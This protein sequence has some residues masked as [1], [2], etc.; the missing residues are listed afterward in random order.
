MTEQIERELAELFR[1]RAERLDVLPPQSPAQVRRGRL[2][3]GLALASVLAVLAGT[4]LAGSRL[5][6]GSPSGAPLTAA[7][8]GQRALADLAKALRKTLAG[9]MVATTTTVEVPSNR[10]VD[11]PDLG[12]SAAMGP[13]ESETTTYDGRHGVAI[14]TRPDGRVDTVFV[15]DVLYVGKDPQND[16]FLPVGVDWISYTRR[17]NESS[18]DWKRRAIRGAIPGLLELYTEPPTSVDE[19]AGRIRLA[20]PD[21][22]GMRSVTV[23]Q[24]DRS[25]VIRTVT[26]RW[27]M[28][29][30][31]AVSDR[32]DRVTFRALRGSM[33]AAEAPSPAHVISSSAYAT[34]KTDYEAQKNCP[35]PPPSTA[36]DGTVYTVQ[37]DCLPPPPDASAEPQSSASPR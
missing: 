25:G 12:F 17:A 28:T 36:P 1:N 33:P 37:V 32:V 8:T 13:G 7:A 31:N 21:I 35:T 29:L 9:R 18:A 15:G 30:A 3:V 16:G 19:R 23:V 34:A 14:A 20:G 10:N 26:S 5:V 2:Q 11:A 24:L 4:V 22:G 27:V 6:D